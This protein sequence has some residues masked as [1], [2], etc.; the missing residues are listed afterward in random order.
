MLPANHHTDTYAVASLWSSLELFI[1]IIA[2]NIALSRSIYRFLR[3]GRQP[4]PQVHSSNTAQGVYLGTASAFRS[5]PSHGSSAAEI[6]LQHHRTDSTTPSALSSESWSRAK[7]QKTVVSRF[8]EDVARL[9][10]QAG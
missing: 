4:G 5:C 9:E 2:A 10:A 1:G 3:Y 6:A 7:T 8:G